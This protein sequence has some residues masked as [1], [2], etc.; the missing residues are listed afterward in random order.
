MWRHISWWQ[1]HPS[2]LFSAK[3]LGVMPD[4][5]FSLTFQLGN[6]IYLKDTQ[7]P[8]TCHHFHC[9]YPGANPILSH[10]QPVVSLLPLSPE[11]RQWDPH[12][13]KESISS[14]N[15][16]FFTEKAL[17]GW[18]AF[19][20]QAGLAGRLRMCEQPSWRGG[21]G[22]AQV[23]ALRDYTRALW[24]LSEGTKGHFEGS[25]LLTIQLQG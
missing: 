3:D 24:G 21:G 12:N 17:G 15:V 5:S 1:L 9:H 19:S 25:C 14:P 6:A 13:S 16:S 20:W 7:R 4:S 2:T 23:S 22:L 11:Q 8:T 10:L 18:L